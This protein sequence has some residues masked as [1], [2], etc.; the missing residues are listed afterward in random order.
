[1]HFAF[2][3]FGPTAWAQDQVS[4]SYVDENGTTQAHNAYKLD[5]Y[6]PPTESAGTVFT[7]QPC[8]H[9]GNAA[10]AR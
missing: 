2:L 5:E 6:L 1:M 8:S 10:T 7:N 4:V 3:A 9:N